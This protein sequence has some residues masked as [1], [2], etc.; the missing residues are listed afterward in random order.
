[1]KECLGHISLSFSQ[2][3]I[4]G[5]L[6]RIFNGDHHSILQDHLYILNFCRPTN[7]KF[8]LHIYIYFIDW[9]MDI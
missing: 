7:L 9:F 2:F 5:I 8:R 6:N 3:I 1:M 4:L